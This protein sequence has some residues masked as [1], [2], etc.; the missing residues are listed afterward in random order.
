MRLVFGR[1][2]FGVW[3]LG[4]A[5]GRLAFGVRRLV[6]GRV[7]GGISG[8]LSRRDITIVAWHEVPGKRSQNGSVP[9]GTV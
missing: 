6:F 2:A 1:L 9:E 5:F 4:S 7:A 8:K 3:R